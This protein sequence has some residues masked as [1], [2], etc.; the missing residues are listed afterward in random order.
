M[1]II[2]GEKSYWGG[3]RATEAYTLILRYAFDRLNLRRV[4]AG[5]RADHLASA[6]TLE[7]VGMVREGCQRQQ[8]LRNGQTTSFCSV[9]CAIEFLDKFPIPASQ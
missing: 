7:K 5:C 1:R 4:F 2:I 3:G 8:F 9:C 6:T